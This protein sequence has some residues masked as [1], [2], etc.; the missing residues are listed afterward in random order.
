MLAKIT[1]SVLFGLLLPWTYFLVVEIVPMDIY[2]NDVLVRN[3]ISKS[4][5]ILFIE[6]H[7][8][9]NAFVLYLKAFIACSL[10]AFIICFAHS[11]M[12]KKINSDL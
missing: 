1:V 12:A 8:W 10:C 6:H 3:T 4:E 7:G 9:P 5:V 11:F 2:E